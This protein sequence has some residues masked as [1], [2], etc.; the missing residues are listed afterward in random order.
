MEL[1]RR[2]GQLDPATAQHVEQLVRDTLALAGEGAKTPSPVQWPQGY[3]E[4]SA[5]ALAGEELERPEQGPLASR[6]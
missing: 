4:R 3:F 5:G 1:D 6:G 2:L